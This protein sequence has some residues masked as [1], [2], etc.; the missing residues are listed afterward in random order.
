MA[1]VD[2]NQVLNAFI[3]ALPFDKIPRHYTNDTSLTPLKGRD[4]VCA[5]VKTITLEWQNVW[6]R[7][8]KN[9][10]KIKIIQKIEDTRELLIREE[11]NKELIDETHIA[12]LLSDMIPEFNDGTYNRL[13]AEREIFLVTQM[14]QFLQQIGIPVPQIIKQYLL[15]QAELH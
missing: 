11:E 3:D 15:E 6:G 14:A 12:Q 8:E 9:F 1:T 5:A 7:S 13:L 10:E 4:G 2:Y